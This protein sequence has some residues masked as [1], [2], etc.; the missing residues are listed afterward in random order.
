M[1]GV[2]VMNGD[3]V[4]EKI[5][6]GT[7]ASPRLDALGSIAFGL[8]RTRMAREIRAERVTLNRDIVADPA[9]TVGTDDVIALEGRGTAV[10]EELSG[11]TRKGRIGVTLKRQY[12]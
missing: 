7:A 10:V 9:K 4:R 11:P 1:A 8:S 2:V 6:R 3:E 12:T 5:V